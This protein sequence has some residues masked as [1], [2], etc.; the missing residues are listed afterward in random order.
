MSSILQGNKKGFSYSGEHRFVFTNDKNIVREKDDHYTCCHED[1]FL[2]NR[3]ILVKSIDT[4]VSIMSWDIY[5]IGQIRFQVKL[6]YPTPNRFILR[7]S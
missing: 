1:F 7:I 6:D 3:K 5:V 2:F 4:N